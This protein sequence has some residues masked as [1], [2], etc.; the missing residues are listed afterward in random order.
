MRH[1]QFGSS[2]PMVVMIN[3]VNILFNDTVTTAAGSQGRDG[4]VSLG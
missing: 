1:S 2:V 4:I 3:K